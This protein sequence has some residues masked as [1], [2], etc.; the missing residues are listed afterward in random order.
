MTVSAKNQSDVE[1]KKSCLHSS[2]I[3][4]DDKNTYSFCKGEDIKDVSK[5]RVVQDVMRLLGIN[6]TEV[7]FN[8]CKD[9]IFS[10][11]Q[12]EKKFRRSHNYEIT[13]PDDDL[14]HYLAPIVH[15]IAHVFQFQ[16]YKS[17]LK[18]MSSLSILRIEL[19]ADYIAGVVYY[20][21]GIK[22]NGYQH[23]VQLIGRYYEV[24]TDHHGTPAQ[25]IAA[26]RMGY[27]DA[28]KES[29]RS[30]QYFNDKFQRDVYGEVIQL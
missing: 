23:S 26:F 16:L 5:D 27:E 24:S 13:Y 1:I 9:Y 19:A 18:L 22:K 29:M 28:R 17:M 12:F 14:V 15:E 3:I 11:K 2:F 30:I 4:G 8:G 10:A 7:A 21:L 6:S 25:R 20:K